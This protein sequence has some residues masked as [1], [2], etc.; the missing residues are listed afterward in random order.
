[1]NAGLP[2]LLLFLIWFVAQPA[3]DLGQSQAKG[4]DAALNTLFVRIWV[5]AMISGCLEA[6]YFVGGGPV[7]IMSLIAVLGLR[8]QARAQLVSDPDPALP[9]LP[10]GT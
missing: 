2:G 8:L 9:F 1:L 7:W 3:R 10:S 6:V 5:Y 4:A